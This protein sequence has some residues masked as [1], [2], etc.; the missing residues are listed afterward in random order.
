ME[1]FFVVVL[2]AAVLAVGAIA[3]VGLRRLKRNMNPPDTQER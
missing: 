3:L 1:A 2:A